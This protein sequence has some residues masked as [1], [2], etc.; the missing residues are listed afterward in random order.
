VAFPSVT[1]RATGGSSSNTTSHSITLPTHSV[2]QMLL[3]VLACDAESARSSESSTTWRKYGTANS[4]SHSTHVFWKIATST[5]ETLTITTNQSDTSAHVSFAISDADQLIIQADLDGTGTANP[6]PPNLDALATR[7]HLWIA[8]ITDLGDRTV[9][10]A[11]S[12][13]SNLTVSTSGAGVPGSTV[14]TAEKTANAQ[15]E[16]PGAFSPDSSLAW[17]GFTIA[18]WDGAVW[19][20]NDIRHYW[21][22]PGNTNSGFDLTTHCEWDSFSETTAGSRWFFNTV[23]NNTI[24]TSDEFNGTMR[25]DQNVDA[26]STEDGYFTVAGTFEDFGVP[27]GTNVT[28][29]KLCGFTYDVE[30]YAGDTVSLF[31]GDSDGSGGALE[32]IE[33]P[34]GSPTSRALIPNQ[35]D[36]NGTL[37]AT[38]VTNNPGITG[39]SLP[40][41][42]QVEFRLHLHCETGATASGHQIRWSNIFVTFNTGTAGPVDYATV[43]TSTSVVT[44]NIDVTRPLIS[45]STVAGTVTGNIDPTRKLIASTAVTSVLGPTPSLDVDR[46]LVSTTTA[47]AI[48]TSDFGVPGI[49]RGGLSAIAIVS[50][51]LQRNTN[52]TSTTTATSTVSATLRTSFVS[53]TSATSTVAAS[54]NVAKTLQSTTTST[55]TVTTYLAGTT[56]FISSTNCSATVLGSLSSRPTIV[57]VQTGTSGSAQNQYTVPLPA[58][59]AGQMIVVFCGFGDNNSPAWDTVGSTAGWRCERQGGNFFQTDVG[60]AWYYK[61]AES[62]SEVLVAESFS[63]EKF[64]TVAYVIDDA[65]GYYIRSDNNGLT[66][67]TQN[68]TFQPITLDKERDVISFA[69]VYGEADSIMTAAPTGYTIDQTLQGGTGSNDGSVSVAIKEAD[70]ITSESPSTATMLNNAAHCTT[71]F[72]AYRRDELETDFEYRTRF[73]DSTTYFDTS[74][75]PTEQVHDNDWVETAANNPNGLNWLTSQDGPSGSSLDDAAFWCLRATDGFQNDSNGFV[76][77]QTTWEELGLNNAS[78][79]YI[80]SYD[81]LELW[82]EVQGIVGASQSARPG[83][84]TSG[85]L[86]IVDPNGTTTLI[87]A[88]AEATAD[89]GWLQLTSSPG[90]I[91]PYRATETI[92]LRIYAQVKDPS[93]EGN[94]QVN[95]EDLRFGVAVDADIP[96]QRT[97]STTVTATSTVSTVLGVPV[98]YDT[99][100]AV[101]STVDNT[102]LRAGTAYWI[103]VQS[104]SVTG[105]LDGA[106]AKFSPNGQWLAVTDA[107]FGQTVVLDASNYSQVA[108]FPQVTRAA[109]AW[110]PDSTELCIGTGNYVNYDLPTPRTEC[111]V[112]VA[113]TSDWSVTSVATLTGDKFY[114]RT[115]YAEWSPNGS[116]LAISANVNIQSDEKLVIL[117]TSSWTIANESATFITANTRDLD[118]KPDSSEIVWCN[119]SDGNLEFVKI[120][121][122][123]GF[124]VTEPITLPVGSTGAVG[125][126]YDRTGSYLAVSQTDSSPLGGDIRVYDT[127]TWVE[128]NSP[129]LA[130]TTGSYGICG[131]EW[132]PY[133]NYLIGGG[134]NDNGVGIELELFETSNAPTTWG[135]AALSSQSQIALNDF[136]FAPNGEKFVA[137]VRNDFAGDTSYVVYELTYVRPALSTNIISA[138]SDVTPKPNRIRP[139]DTT[140]ASTSGN[141]FVLETQRPLVTQ[142]SVDATVVP[143]AVRALDLIGQTIATSTVDGGEFF[144]TVFFDGASVTATSTV[145]PNAK[146]TVNLRTVINVTSTVTNFLYTDRIEGTT[147][148]SNGWQDTNVAWGGDVDTT[149]TG[150]KLSKPGGFTGSDAYVVITAYPFNASTTLLMNGTAA[151][152]FS[153]ATTVGPFVIIPASSIVTT[154]DLFVAN[155]GSGGGQVA[156]CWLR[157]LDSSTPFNNTQSGTG[158]ISI[159]ASDYPTDAA[160][161][162]GA[163]KSTSNSFPYVYPSF[164][165]TNLTEPPGND[166]DY[167]F[168]NNPSANGRL[169]IQDTFQGTITDANHQITVSPGSGSTT[170]ST[171]LVSLK[172]ALR[173][174][175]AL[176]AKVFANADANASLFYERPFEALTTATTT[177]TSAIDVARPLVSTTSV[178]ALVTGNIDQ[179]RK[180]MSTSVVQSAVIEPTQFNLTLAYNSTTNAVSTVDPNIGLTVFYDSTTNVVST[181]DPGQFYY[182]FEGAVAATS[183]VSATL[184]V[185]RP[186]I[187]TTA[188]STAVTQTVNTWRT[189]NWNSVTSVASTV[190]SAGGEFD[191]PLRADFNGFCV[192]V[193]LMSLS[194]KLAS[195]ISVTS[196][197]DPT[198]LQRVRGYQTLVAAQSD[199]LVNS[200]VGK[201]LL[202]TVIGQSAV[203]L[204]TR[205]QITRNMIAPITSVSSLTVAPLER[206]IDFDTSLALA[207][208]VTATVV[209]ITN[210]LE[211]TWSETY[212]YEPEPYILRLRT[213]SFDNTV[214][215]NEILDPI[216][217]SDGDVLPVMTINTDDDGP[218]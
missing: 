133:S 183:T 58:H 7:D 67:G 134:E 50:P 56:R 32:I 89:T 60:G 30:T 196:A 136:S 170:Y 168:S 80:T 18:V 77:F 97:F 138:N 69:V 142:V 41:T 123:P 31:A 172:S 2:G 166:E 121:S 122:V 45:T 162:I 92:T 173:Y 42:T 116:Y 72:I 149:I 90:A 192:A 11:P 143:N 91:T 198:E 131:V 27:S 124:T 63:A 23:S 200:E 112:Y 117:N 66:T 76:E 71:T 202:T 37:A 87:A 93:S 130:D 128:Q 61:I 155:D 73:N 15:T 144:D 137:S 75:T 115:A 135:D 95:F 184:E 203:I 88:P 111:D 194:G 197:I 16:N 51:N 188:S 157:G 108:S 43:V 70:N 40:S 106:I 207:T 118:W 205:L 49:M 81:D 3:V 141:V 65:N 126:S 5:S 54:M 147:I 83:T 79:S 199:L 17:A 145:T 20:S 154:Y 21:R 29:Y 129:V 4:S 216:Q 176:A 206:A 103:P 104:D 28:G 150:S 85:A 22:I 195:V 132:S 174:N 161:G 175:V 140:I 214:I 78:Y 209:V 55:S 151:G 213:D 52:F 98:F 14:A 26:N 171:G 156:W 182:G 125:V 127:T 48:V 190:F 177:T 100:I 34:S 139:F 68:P 158:N 178:T 191:R 165:F 53:S 19:D 217:R 212:F 164:T 152:S 9:S 105:I 94:V 187:S 215:V 64:H 25:W 119:N 107:S 12:G 96:G 82:Y 101:V 148:I 153:G 208:T 10:A 204:P 185:D 201:T 120:I 39:L 6:N 44:P 102:E 169:T 99:A 59:T 110:S 186:I 1:A 210:T 163:G 113:D 62:S 181:V 35:A 218:A 160:I 114:L 36:P 189:V 167:F 146:R 33:D 179:Q 24:F 84:D 211:L 74:G 57:G 180:L 109:L 193:G 159:T 46:P 8:A 47:T 38:E 86:E 13:Y